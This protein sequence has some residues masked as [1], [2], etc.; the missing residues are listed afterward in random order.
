MR[1][2]IKQKYGEYAKGKIMALRTR[3]DH[4]VMMAQ[5]VQ[6]GPNWSKI[7]ENGP[8]EPMGPKR[9][10]LFD[11]NNH[12]LESMM[13]RK[14]NHY[15]TFWLNAEHNCRYNKAPFVGDPDDGTIKT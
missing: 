2:L 10:N 5:V 7:V 6:N 1:N 12:F 8:I 11:S 3:L 13:V 9:S 15:H 4:T 14:L